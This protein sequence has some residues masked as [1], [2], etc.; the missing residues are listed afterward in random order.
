MTG[1]TS[2]SPVFGLSSFEDETCEDEASLEEAAC[3]ADEA[4]PEDADELT[5][6]ADEAEDTVPEAAED[7]F[8]L[9]FPLPDAPQP[10]KVMVTAA[11]KAVIS[12]RAFFLFDITFLQF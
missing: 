3:A 8:E 5:E 10:V 12:E 6:A 9:A 4:W 1:V 2:V 7:V 11:T